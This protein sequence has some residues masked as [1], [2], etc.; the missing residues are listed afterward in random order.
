MT[1]KLVPSP[2][3]LER[4]AEYADSVIRRLRTE[5]DKRPPCLPGMPELIDELIAQFERTEA[6]LTRTQTALQAAGELI[7][8]VSNRVILETVG[9]IV[10][11]KPAYD[12]YAAALARLAGTRGEAG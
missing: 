12:T 10:D 6:E 9:D 7:D 5:T 3:E 4:M 2:S 1:I 8:K 11:L